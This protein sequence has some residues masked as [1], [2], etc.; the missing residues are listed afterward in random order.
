MS[1]H[2]VSRKCRIDF[3]SLDRTAKGADGISEPTWMSTVDNRPFFH[4]S[5]EIAEEWLT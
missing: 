3:R 1:V 2:A 5:L 4:G